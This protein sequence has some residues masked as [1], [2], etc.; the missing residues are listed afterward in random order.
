M[1][2]VNWHDCNLPGFKIE[3]QVDCKVR[4]DWEQEQRQGFKW[5][6]ALKN[7][8]IHV[9]GFFMKNIVFDIYLGMV[10]YSYAV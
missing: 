6:G 8:E 7:M 9:M 4:Q 2:V 3:N 5:G 10:G 1:S